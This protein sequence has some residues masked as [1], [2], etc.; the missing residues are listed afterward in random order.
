[1]RGFELAF[2]SSFIAVTT[3]LF[4]NCGYKE[5]QNKGAKKGHKFKTFVFLP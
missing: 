5:N 4:V 2:A 3:D 1:M